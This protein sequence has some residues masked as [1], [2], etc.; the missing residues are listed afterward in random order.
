MIPILITS[1]YLQ[2]PNRLD[3][4]EGIE[5]G[6]SEFAQRVGALLIPLRASAG[7]GEYFTE[8]SP[9]GV[10]L[11]G[12]NDIA[13][14]VDSAENRSRDAFEHQLISLA[15]ERDI[16][17][18]AVCRGMQY[19][20]SQGGYTV[21]PIEGHVRTRHTITV[22]PGSSLA[23]F[24]DGSSVNSFHQWGVRGTSAEYRA[25]AHSEDGFIEAIE[26]LS[27]KRCGV[28][29]HP[30]REPITQWMVHY[31]QSFFGMRVS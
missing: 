8:L 18:F 5:S 30:E 23:R 11:S 24:Y 7:C 28:L 22:D 17:V 1:M 10:I 3:L 4:L 31:V 12:G 21:E 27:L 29:W 16:P 20:A 2:R 6:W 19:L 26:H 14:C 9:K 25:V 15:E 13:P